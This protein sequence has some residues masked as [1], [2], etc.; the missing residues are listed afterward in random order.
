MHSSQTSPDLFG[1]AGAQPT[2]IGEI[3]RLTKLVNG[4]QATIDRLRVRPGRATEADIAGL[5][6]DLDAAVRE[7]AWIEGLPARFAASVKFSPK[8]IPLHA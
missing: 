5:Q 2:L 1:E 4:L 8:P 3:M 6:R 7:R